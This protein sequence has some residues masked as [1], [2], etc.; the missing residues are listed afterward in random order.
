M[1]RR[2]SMS[3]LHCTI[4]MRPTKPLVEISQAERAKRRAKNKQAG[5][6]RRKAA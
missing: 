4:R 5:K 2:K 1:S 3:M 6:A